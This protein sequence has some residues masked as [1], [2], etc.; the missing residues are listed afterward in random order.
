[1]SSQLFYVMLPLDPSLNSLCRIS[2]IRIKANPRP[3]RKLTN[4]IHHLL[5]TQQI[6][7]HSPHPRPN[8]H[9]IIF[10]TLQHIR[11]RL[12]Q[13]L[14][15]RKAHRYTVAALL[16]RRLIMVQ[17]LLHLLRGEVREVCVVWVGEVDGGWLDADE[18][19]F[20]HGEIDVTVL[21][22]DVDAET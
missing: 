18:K 11:R 10:R 21:F 16:E 19:D 12:R 9:T 1:M 15:R 13:L 17:A 22:A 7:L 20:C 5:K 6:R 3:S 8:Q 2:R 4:H 14:P